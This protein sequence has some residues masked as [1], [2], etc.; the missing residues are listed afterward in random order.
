MYDVCLTGDLN[1]NG[2][3][4]EH[5]LGVGNS[6][7]ALIKHWSMTCLLNQHCKSPSKDSKLLDY[8]FATVCRH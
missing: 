4:W 8:I 7:I 3:N 2:I 1:C 6:V 5:E